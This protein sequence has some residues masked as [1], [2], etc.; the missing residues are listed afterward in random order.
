MAQAVVQQL[1]D[2]G[3]DVRLEQVDTATYVERWSSSFDFDLLVGL[4][5]AVSPTMVDPFANL[6]FLDWIFAGAPTDQARVAYEASIGAPD[7]AAMDEI[8][9][10]LEDWALEH[11]PFVPLANLDLVTARVPELR[12][13]TLDRMGFYQMQ[14]VYLQE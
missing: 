2:V 1:G 5:Y 13:V 6:T 12:G 9:V 14:N 7:D 8:T 10:G 4:N 11:I 3:I